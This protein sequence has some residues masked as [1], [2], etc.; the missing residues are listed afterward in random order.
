MF[1][2]LRPKQQDLLKLAG[3]L[4]TLTSAKVLVIDMVSFQLVQKV[5]A[6]IVIGCILLFVAYFYQRNKNDLQPE[7]YQS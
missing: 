7:N 6:F 2:S 4:F 1:I 5:I 3:I